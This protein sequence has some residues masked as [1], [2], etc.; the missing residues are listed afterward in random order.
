MRERDLYQA[1]EAGARDDGLRVFRLP[2]DSSV[3]RPADF[4]GVDLPTGLGALVE[5]KL[6]RRLRGSD[7]IPWTTLFET[8]QVGWLRQ[9]AEACALPLVAVYD[10][11]EACMWAFRMLAA[12]A[13]LRDASFAWFDAPHARLSGTRSTSFTGWRELIDVKP[14]PLGS[15]EEVASALARRPP[16]RL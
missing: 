4:A 10:E 5:V 15:D 9:Y 1:V 2:D 6:V 16:R 8:Q 11:S 13:R 12:H 3:K 14:T 7:P